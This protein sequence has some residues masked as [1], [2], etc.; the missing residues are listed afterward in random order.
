VA[1]SLWSVPDLS[2]ALLV[3]KFYRNLRAGDSPAQALRQAQRWLR[4][5]TW[6]EQS[7]ELPADR[8][9]G[10]DMLAQSPLGQQRPAQAIADWAAF[11]VTA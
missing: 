8:R 4:D 7:A 6:A 11:V 9:P 3:R 2:T 5:S 1:G 10:G